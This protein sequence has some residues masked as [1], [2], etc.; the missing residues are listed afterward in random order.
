ME[1]RLSDEKCKEILKASINR[2]LDDGRKMILR[3]DLWVYGESNLP[4]IMSSLKEWESR[5]LLKILTNPEKARDDAIC[6][7]MLKYI[8]QD[9]P[10]EGWPS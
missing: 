3:S 4:V 8:D 7:E 2:I 1:E 9:S 5:G 6:I 10:K